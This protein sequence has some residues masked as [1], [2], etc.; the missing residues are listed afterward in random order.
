MNRQLTK[1]RDFRQNYLCDIQ[2][3]YRN[4]SVAD[5]GCLSLIL[6]PDFCPYRIP[7]PGSKNA[8]KERDEKIFCCPTFFCSHKY[9]KIEKYFIF[10]L[11]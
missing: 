6:D 11:V 8:T 7:D 1:S 9:H 3:I 5:P 10:E 2:L 4:I